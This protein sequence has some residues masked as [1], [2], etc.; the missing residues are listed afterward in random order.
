[1]VDFESY[2][3][4]CGRFPFPFVWPLSFAY[5]VVRH[6]VLEIPVLLKRS[7]R[8]LLAQ[9]GFTILLL[10]LWLTAIRLFT[11]AVSG[12]VGTFSN[13]VLVLG[14]VFGVGLVW[15]SAPAV[16]RA[17]ERIDRAFFRS[18]YDT[19]QILE[20]LVGET[21][22]VTSREE[23]AA[24]PRFLRF[25]SPPSRR[26]FADP[27]TLSGIAAGYSDAVPRY[28]AEPPKDHGQLRRAELRVLSGQFWGTASASRECS[29]SEPVRMHF[30]YMPVFR[31]ESSFLEQGERST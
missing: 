26:S 29:D 6:R 20:S 16:N 1:M 25:N 9:R 13:T 11:F 5:A 22:T 18:A 14:L 7:A 31:V 23:L 10:I 4:F 17:T 30:T 21:R 15:F 8:Y 28:P 24:L 2:L 27:K 3:W 12:L 19:R